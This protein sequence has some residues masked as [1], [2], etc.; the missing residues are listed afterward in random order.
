VRM[1]APLIPYT[2]DEIYGHIP[3]ARRESVHLLRLQEARPEVA[4]SALEGR[5]E[6]FLGLRDH[7]LKVLEEM[8]KQ[9]TIGAPLE[10]VV[11]LGSLG[12]P[13]GLLKDVGTY[14]DQLADLFIVSGVSFLEPADARA[15]T[16][17]GGNSSRNGAHYSVVESLGWVV[18]AKRAPGLKC[19]RCWKYYDD[20]GNPELCPRC[21]AVLRDLSR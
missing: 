13:D 4:N 19:Q 9:G 16:G 7:V 17:A 18:G 20:G 2:A 15:I 6:L 8:R 12:K 10:A 5:W 1:L 3:G 21:R 11:Q 14:K